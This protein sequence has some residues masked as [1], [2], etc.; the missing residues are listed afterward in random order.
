V[1]DAQIAGD[2]GAAFAAKLESELWVGTGSSGRIRGLTQA[3]PGTTVTAGGVTVANQLGAIFN[4]YQQLTVALGRPPDL[5]AVHPRRAAWWAQSVAG[6]PAKYVPDGVTLVA[7]PA[8][9]S[10]LGSG[11]NEDNPHFLVRDVVPLAIDPPSI[12]VQ[13][14]Q[15]GTSMTARAI[16][17]CYCAFATNAALRRPGGEKAGRC[18]LPRP[19]SPLV[20]SWR[21]PLQSTNRLTAGSGGFAAELGSPRRLNVAGNGYE[22][23]FIPLLAG[24]TRLRPPRESGEDWG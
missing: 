4:C 8:A 11:T 3:S 17:V 18:R 16:L 1:A 6:A 24:E 13:P 20:H 21:L 22:C 19:R 9:P 12:D 5:L 2:L 7:S 15:S 10:N 23:A 14:Q